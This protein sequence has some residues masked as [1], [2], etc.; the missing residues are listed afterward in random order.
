MNTPD[1][2]VK[3]REEEEQHAVQS[4]EFFY[5]A[6]LPSQEEEGENASEKIILQ[7]SSQFSLLLSLLL[8]LR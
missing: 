8:M 4:F 7:V 5:L 6:I 3:M 2:A 1:A